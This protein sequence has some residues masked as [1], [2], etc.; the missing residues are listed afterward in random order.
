MLTAPSLSCLPPRGNLAAQN[1]SFPDL[2]RPI[3]NPC[4]ACTVFSGRNSLTPFLCLTNKFLLTLQDP[5]QISPLS[6]LRTSQ[7]QQGPMNVK[8]K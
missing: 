8:R 3:L 1:C 6:R 7:K 2:D 4:F 5:S